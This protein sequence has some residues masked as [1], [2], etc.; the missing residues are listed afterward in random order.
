MAVSPGETITV[1]HGKPLTVVLEN[2][3]SETRDD[4]DFHQVNIGED[5]RFDPSYKEYPGI[6]INGNTLTIAEDI[7]TGDVVIH[8]AAYVSF[9]VDMAGGTCTNEGIFT[10]TDDG[11]AT[12]TD[13]W[14]GVGAYITSGNLFKKDGHSLVKLVDSKGNEY[15]ANYQFRITGDLHLTL[16]WDECKNLTQVPGTLATC[17]ETGIADHWVC[18]CGATYADE[19]GTQPMDVTTEIAPD[20]HSKNTNTAVTCLGTQCSECEK[21]YGEPDPDAHSFDAS[22][23]CTL[24]GHVCDH[25]GHTGEYSKDDNNHTFTCTVCKLEVTGQ[26]HDYTHNANT[27]TCICGDVEQFTIT[28]DM[29]GCD[30]EVYYPGELPAKLAYNV[31]GWDHQIDFAWIEAPAGHRFVKFVDG[32]GKEL[33]MDDRTGSA[34]YT[35]RLWV[36]VSGDMTIKAVIEPLTYTATWTVNGEEVGTTEVKFGETIEAPA[37]AVPEGYTFSGWEVPETMP[38]E[39]ITLNATLTPID[40]TLTVDVGAT[41]ETV[42]LTVP[43]GANLMEVLAKAETEGKL[44]AKGDEFDRVNQNYNGINVITGSYG[45][46]IS[47]SYYSVDDTA[48]MPAYD[49]TVN[50][51]YTFRGW[52]AFSTS[53]LNTRRWRYETS[54]GTLGEG[55]HDIEENFD[56]VPGGARYYFESVNDYAGREK[57]VRVEGITEI[58]GKHYCFDNQGRFRETFTGILEDICF[59]KGVEVATKLVDN[60]NGTHRIACAEH[61]NCTAVFVE[62]ENHTYVDSVCACN[63]VCLHENNTNKPTDNGDGTHNQTCSVCGKVFADHE[64]H[65]GG[66]ATCVSGK[67]CEIC[68]TEYTE[69]DVTNH[70]GGTEVKNAKDATCGEAGYTGDTCCKSCGEVLT[71][72]TTIKATGNH[73]GGTATCSD[74]AICAV[75]ENA[76]GELDA[77][78]HAG[79]TE[80]LTKGTAIAAT[81]D[82]TGGTATCSDKAICTVCENAYGELDAENHAGG[83]EVKNAKD[84]TCGEAGYTGDTCCKSCGDVLTKGTTIK[85]TGEHTYGNWKEVKEA[86]KTAKGEKQRTCLVCGHVESKEIP[87]L[88][89]TPATGDDTNIFL[90]SMVMCIS[91]VCLLVILASQKKR[92]FNR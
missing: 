4:F 6:D 42:E 38:A 85:A 68:F 25:S 48:I 9:T 33:S 52:A 13:D 69:P 70:A 27:H 15:A 22:G 71:K 21:S 34:F 62:A 20:H 40:Y 54:E 84:A 90:W 53:D 87:V 81:G 77:E 78:N 89:D 2:V 63:A 83:T 3:A 65:S 1:E 41:D 79:G 11:I 5:I 51:E 44:P 24:C 29:S 56:D 8:A 35:H 64:S 37:Y 31:G 14:S 55:W 45:R 26:K 28:W 10:A 19:A 82:H 23:Q 91:A 16:V 75:C 74:K 7:V 92:V 76:Y 61:E 12:L 72:G 80:V 30:Y 49:L 39:D 67:N 32:N 73:T 66:E 57:A 18:A 60:G 17:T 86:T 50:Q 36:T 46:Y 88:S 47:G 58:E 43:Y 59:E